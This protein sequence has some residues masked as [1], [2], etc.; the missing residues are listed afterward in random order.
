MNGKLN[1]M[2]IISKPLYASLP[3]K[4]LNGLVPR[5]L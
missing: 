2:L 3:N 1:G 4:A 5:P